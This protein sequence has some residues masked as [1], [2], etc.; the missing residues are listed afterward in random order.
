MMRCR[1]DAFT[2]GSS[3]AFTGERSGDGVASVTS[4]ASRENPPEPRPWQGA[5]WRSVSRSTELPTEVANPAGDVPGACRRETRPPRRTA[6]RQFPD[7][8]ALLAA[9]RRC[10]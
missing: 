4:T 2:N 1:F 10:L 9:A 7:L 8:Q 6:A 5:P 3:L